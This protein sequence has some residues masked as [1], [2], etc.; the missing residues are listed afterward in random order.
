VIVPPES[1][2]P[3]IVR[4][5][6]KYEVLLSV[7]EV[8]TGF[9]RVGAWFSAALYGFAAGLYCHGQGP[10][11][12]VCTH[13]RRVGGRPGNG[14]SCWPVRLRLNHGFTYSGHPTAA[15]VAL[16]NLRLLDEEG[17]HCPGGKL[18]P[19]LISSSDWPSYWLTIRWWAMC[20]AG[21]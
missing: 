11:L 13:L 18:I 10:L 14:R 15:A 19:A 2:W 7:D 17:R 12:R 8:I 5:C 4:I 9:G 20:V 21:P 3:E 1:Y 16:E 6:R